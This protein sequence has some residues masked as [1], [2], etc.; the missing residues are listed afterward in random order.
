MFL[1]ILLTNKKNFSV[2]QAMQ[3]LVQFNIHLDSQ[4][5]VSIRI[6]DFDQRSQS[7]AAQL[8]SPGFPYLLV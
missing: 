5:W 4:H 6:Q 8:G 2:V 1:F 7:D 3:L